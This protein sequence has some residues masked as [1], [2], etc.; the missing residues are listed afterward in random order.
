MHKINR[1]GGPSRPSTNWRR[2]VQRSTGKAALAGL[3][4]LGCSDITRVTTPDVVTTDDLDTPDGALARRAGAIAG[5]ATAFAGQVV[6]SG[7]IADEFSDRT[8]SI[9]PAQRVI[10][11]DQR[12]PYAQL[13]TARINSLRAIEA[14]QQYNPTPPE[15]IGELYA[16]AG[17]VALFFGENLCSGVP[18]GMVD[19]GLPTVSQTYTRRS[20]FER[21][22]AEFDSASAYGAGSGAIISL[23]RVGRGRALL[24]LGEWEQA[25]NA[26][27]DV[28]EGFDYQVQY[29]SVTEQRN[30]IY[31]LIVERRNVS[32][33]DRE[34][35]NGLPF[36]SAED[37]RLRTQDVGPGF[38][39]GR[40]INFI[41]NAA[42]DSPIPL[43]SWIEAELIRA[44]SLLGAGQIDQW[45]QILNSLR[46]NAITP[47][48]E[49]LPPDST[50][51][52]I[53]AAR[54][55]LM[56]RE[57]AFWLFGT[58]HRHADL[59]RLI[60]VYGRPT[61]TVFPTGLYQGGPRV[62]GPDVV[63]T[64]TGEESN[65]AY[66]GCMDRNP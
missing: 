57:R 42:P 20:L 5:F 44:E 50:L 36:V 25:A 13:S 32:M 30:G 34:G 14:L 64:P 59:R 29:S 47:P 51:Q 9:Q 48:M 4:L 16:L 58:G 24:A 1:S 65:P 38:A 17:Y 41:T 11:L 23:A 37:P 40:V 10:T 22:L 12:Y 28:P 62:Y 49:P 56:F 35:V 15:R 55:D 52:A 45:A 2:S 53:S 66:S 27:L 7:I 18:L 6:F 19:E 60:R 21:A 26:I 54:V 43:A 3:V 39:G 33:S 31:D 61:E 63:F 46:Q 8:G